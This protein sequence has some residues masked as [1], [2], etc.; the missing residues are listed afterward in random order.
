MLQQLQTRFMKAGLWIALPAA[1]AFGQSTGNPPAFDSA[2]VHVSP[3]SANP[4][5]R[6][7]ALRGGRYE[8]RTATM[9]DLIAAAYNVDTDKI[10][11]GPSW[12]DWDRFD[13]LAKA[14]AATT[15]ENLSLMLQH[16]LVP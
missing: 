16:L 1:A 4:A 2:D 12:L 3:R 11:S 14:P 8:V 13:V 15:R 7:G 9:V 10:L 6:G 5:M